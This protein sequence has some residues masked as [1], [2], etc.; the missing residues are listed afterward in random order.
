MIKSLIFK[1]ISHY[2]SFH[3]YITNV[4]NVKKFGKPNNITITYP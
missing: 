4:K 1:G 3:Q 2:R